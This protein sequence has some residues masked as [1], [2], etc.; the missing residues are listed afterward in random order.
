MYN[1]DIFNNINTIKNKSVNKYISN[2]IIIIIFLVL[3][4]IIVSI[5]YEYNNKYH[6]IGQVIIDD[7]K[8]YIKT[9]IEENKINLIYNDLIFNNNK[10]DFKIKSFGNEYLVDE[11][12][13]KYYEVNLLFELEYK[14]LINNNIIDIYFK[15]EKTTL[16]KQLKKKIK[17]GMI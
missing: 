12:N 16:Y 9:Y 3:S 4:F 7:N 11:K 1:I 14:Y 8:Y 2:Y 6:I 5:K 10:V 17:K 13:I 15:E